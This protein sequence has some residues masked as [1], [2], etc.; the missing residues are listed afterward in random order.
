MSIDLTL[1]AMR[2]HAWRLVL[3]ARGQKRPAGDTW[4]ITSDPAAVRAHLASGCGVGIVTGESCVVVMDFDDMKAHDQMVAKLG[5]VT[6]WVTSPSGGIHCYFNAADGLPAKITWNGATV[7]EVQ[8][9]ERQH[10]CMPPSPYAGKPSKGIPPG[11]TYVWLTDPRGDLPALPA[12]W[13]EYLLEAPAHIQPGDARGHEY[14]SSDW[15]GDPVEVL[16]KRALKQPGARLRKK[17]VHFQCA[18][19]AKAGRDRSMDNAI[20]FIPSGKFTCTTDREAHRG[21]IAR[22]LRLGLDYE[23]PEAP[24]CEDVEGYVDP[25]TYPLAENVPG[26]IDPMDYPLAEDV[27]G[28]VDPMDYPLQEEADGA[29]RRTRRTRRSAALRVKQ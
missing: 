21:D 15:R 7:G 19:C 26:H 3:L 25:M 29:P 4:R 2:K 8:R 12:A 24:L 28:Y 22:Q 6:P 1:E 27:P 16:M 17:G 5:P 18:G 13:A 11:G 10:V 20:V 14:D 9:G 23:E